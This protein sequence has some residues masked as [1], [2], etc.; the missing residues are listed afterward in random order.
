M[1]KLKI[2]EK[3]FEGKEEKPTTLNSGSLVDELKTEMVLCFLTNISIPDYS[4][5][6]QH[7]F[8]PEELDL[9]R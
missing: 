5:H 3:Q 1:M 7:L 8:D 9:L 6:G 4:L 2:Y